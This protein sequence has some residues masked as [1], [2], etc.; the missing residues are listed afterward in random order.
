[1]NNI[2]LSGGQASAAL[3]QHIAVV[4]HLIEF[5]EPGFKA[6]QRC[7]RPEKPGLRGNGGRHRR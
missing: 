5:V 3:L 2:G 4:A 7:A 6:T 1:M